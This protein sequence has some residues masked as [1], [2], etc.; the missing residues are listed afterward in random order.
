MNGLIGMT[1]VG[2]AEADRRRMVNKQGSDNFHKHIPSRI[3]STQCALM[4]PRSWFAVLVKID[5][6]KSVAVCDLSVLSRSS[7]SAAVISRRDL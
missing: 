7:A 2:D 3:C 6:D 1:P 4:L 5:S